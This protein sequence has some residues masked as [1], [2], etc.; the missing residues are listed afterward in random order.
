MTTTGLHP[1]LTSLSDIQS[2]RQRLKGVALVTPLQPN[3]NLSRKH[4]SDI[5]L[6]REDLQVVR[7]Y[8]IR[9]AYNK[10]MQLSP[11][12]KKKG[13]VCASAGNHAQGVAYSCHRLGIRGTVFM[14][15][16]TPQQKIQ[17][18]RM[19]GGE[20]IEVVIT[21]D[22]FDESFQAARQ[23]EAE[24]DTVFVHPFNDPA[25]IAG[26]GTVGWEILDASQGAID[27]LLVPVGGGG[28]A[29]GVGTVFRNLSPKTK[30]IGVEPAGAASMHASLEA[31]KRIRLAQI[32]PFV[33]GA[34]T[35][36]VGDLTLAHC[37]AVL[38]R[39]ITVPEGRICTTILELYN[40]D[41]IVVE[42]A[43]ALT[44]AA[45]SQLDVRGKKVV[46]V[47]SGS[48]NDIVRME[49]IKERSLLY[50][51]LKH[52]FIVRFPQRPG[53]LKEFVLHVLGPRDD[54]THF[55]YTKKTSREQGPAV[56][57]IELQQPEDF[58]PLW[59]RMEERGFLGEYLNQKEELFQY[60][61]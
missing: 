60:L 57:G 53:A 33:D 26:Q 5:W 36:T 41:A 15:N 24:T 2:A 29:S 35:Q 44:V 31:G 14:P 55:A 21:G 42:P 3:A 20:Q 46:C 6:K 25:I 30:I 11:A 52:Y 18:V 23:H 58:E 4:H 8:K 59:Q 1:S 43:G 19:F 27:Y 13:I 9:G 28:L 12:Q 56:V 54:I 48:N 61:V 17:Q 49:E 22:T 40:R 50:E 34:A 10:I 45:L 38:D 32:D 39:V 51:G 37:Q 7:S 16:P 47:L